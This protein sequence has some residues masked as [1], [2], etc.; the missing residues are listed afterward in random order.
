MN[1]LWKGDPPVQDAGDVWRHWCRVLK[2]ELTLIFFPICPHCI[3]V[4]PDAQKVI[5]QM[6]S[7][8]LR[9]GTA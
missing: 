7:V 1:R 9:E 5:D 6:S 2:Y 4:E 8:M 3:D